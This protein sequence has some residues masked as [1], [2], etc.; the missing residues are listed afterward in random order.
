LEENT[1]R[2]TGIWDASTNP[3]T[4]SA[5]PGLA[6]PNWGNYAGQRYPDVVANIRV[7]QP[8]GS[9]QIH[10]ALHDASA[11]CFGTFCNPGGIN[12]DAQDATGWAAGAGVMFNLPWAQGDQL[13]IQGTWARGA[14]SYLGF[15]K[16]AANDLFAMY[17]NTGTP[18]TI[19]SVGL[20]WAFDGIFQTGT[21]VS[22]TEGFQVNAAAQH[23]WTPALRTSVFGNYG[24]L[25]FNATGTALFCTGLSGGAAPAAGTVGTSPLAVCNPDFAVWQVGSRTIW[26]PV[27]NLD[28]GVEVLYTRFDQNMVGAWN[29]GA[30]GARAAGLYEAR[31][32]DTWS[33][34]L[35]FQRNFWP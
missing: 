28:I 33:G 2:R 26:S 20:G 27:A 8:W 17:G 21:P 12:T 29:L 10:A 34:V 4:N 25:D 24:R 9:A 19:G 31:D 16:N 5:F 18:G 30:S 22:L 11:S 13:W 7:D 1:E 3:L 14:A 6:Q 32:Q 35:R 15:N 23:F